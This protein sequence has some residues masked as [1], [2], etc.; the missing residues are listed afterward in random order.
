MSPPPSLARCLSPP[1]PPL[2]IA[3][4]LSGS[5]PLR[6]R[7][8]CPV[9]LGRRQPLLRLWVVVVTMYRHLSMYFY[10]LMSSL[11]DDWARS[12][13]SVFSFNLS[14]DHSLSTL[15][16][17]NW[18][19]FDI[20]FVSKCKSEN[21]NGVIP[22]DSDHFQPTT[23]ASHPL[24]YQGVKPQSQHFAHQYTPNVVL[25]CYIALSLSLFT[26]RLE[27]ETN[28]SSMNS[29]VCVYIHRPQNHIKPSWVRNRL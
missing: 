1:L 2:T 24:C 7:L 27:E 21:G 6:P 16:R 25:V 28:R 17:S 19:V 8:R 3:S 12:Y 14:V 9:I 18:F 13:G 22:T 15:I 5:C 20:A 23:I 4:R 26:L 29:F 10:V 11:L